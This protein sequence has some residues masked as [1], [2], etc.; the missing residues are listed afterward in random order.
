M[1]TKRSLGNSACEEQVQLAERELAAFLRAVAQLF[2]P[3]EAELSAEE[4]LEES[5]RAKRSPGAKARHWR[6]V[7]IAASARLAE[8]LT[9][10]QST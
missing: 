10:T 4:W 1:T 8:R 9:A 5:H 6:D 3:D 2:G 7:S